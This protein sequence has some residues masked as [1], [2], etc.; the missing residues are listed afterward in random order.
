VEKHPTIQI[1]VQIKLA[2]GIFGMIDHLNRDIDSVLKK[3]LRSVAKNNEEFA[4][5]QAVYQ[6]WQL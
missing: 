1:S 4:M 2:E 6:F 5:G 3:L